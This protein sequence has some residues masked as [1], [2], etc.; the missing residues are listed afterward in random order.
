MPNIFEGLPMPHYEGIEPSELEIER[1]RK[2][3]EES[4]FDELSDEHQNWV[5]G[6]LMPSLT[7]YGFYPPPAS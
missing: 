7:R 1:I 3:I 4:R 6:R 5:V 2:Y